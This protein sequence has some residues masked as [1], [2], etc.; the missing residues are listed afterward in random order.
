MIQLSDPALAKCCCCTLLRL[1]RCDAWSLAAL[2]QR[3]WPPAG[4][5]LLLVVVCTAADVI[6]GLVRPLATGRAA[7]WGPGRRPTATV[8]IIMS[9]GKTW[10]DKIALSP[11]RQT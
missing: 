2:C 1:P 6:R 9:S 8:Y 4:W 10:H 11:P 5:L 3:P 7:G